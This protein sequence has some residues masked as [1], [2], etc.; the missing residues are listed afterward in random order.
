MH[1]LQFNTEYD[2]FP[3]FFSMGAFIDSIHMKL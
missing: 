3:D 1:I 2:K